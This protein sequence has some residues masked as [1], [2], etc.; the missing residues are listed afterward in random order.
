MLRA[1]T[2]SLTVGEVVVDS[3]IREKLV[4]VSHN[5]TIWLFSLCKTLL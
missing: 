4:A 1:G 3:H 5:V 2:V